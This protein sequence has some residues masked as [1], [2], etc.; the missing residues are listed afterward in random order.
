V[1]GAGIMKMLPLSTS[2][3]QDFDDTFATNVPTFNVLRQAARRLSDGSRI[4]TLSSSVLALSPAGIRPYAGPRRLSRC[5]RE[6]SPM[7]CADDR[8][9]VNAVAPG[10]TAMELFSE[11]KSQEQIDRFT[12]LPPLEPL[13]TPEDIA[14]VVSFLAGADGGWVNGQV[15]RANGGYA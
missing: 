14:N 5:S 3:E 11:G 8:S 10:A 2:N 15:L 9:N 4:V 7:S 12:H 1:N 6:R 13:E